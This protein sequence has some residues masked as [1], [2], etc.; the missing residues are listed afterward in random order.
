M[1]AVGHTPAACANFTGK[2]STVFP[3]AAFWI[4]KGFS[5]ARLMYFLATRRSSH[6]WNTTRT[7]LFSLPVSSSLSYAIT[8]F[9]GFLAWARSGT[10]FTAWKIS[11]GTH[12]AES[13]SQILQNGKVNAGLQY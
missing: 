10:G 4:L 6:R 1:Q 12:F 7:W 2:T 9:A 5:Q 13:D 3:I 8:Q 11:S